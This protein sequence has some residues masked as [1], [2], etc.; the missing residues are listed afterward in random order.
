VRGLVAA[1]GVIGAFVLYFVGAAFGVNG[2]QW[3]WWRADSWIAAV[4]V[5]AATTWT[6]WRIDRPLELRLAASRPVLYL[7]ALA[8]G[9]T[10]GVSVAI[11]ADR[12]SDPYSGSRLWPDVLASTALAG[13]TLCVSCLFASLRLFDGA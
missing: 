2:T 7:A 8:G 13:F 5:L 6:V 12:Y 3:N 4:I 9:A 11:M 10:I 1:S